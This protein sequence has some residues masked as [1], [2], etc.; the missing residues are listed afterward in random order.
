MAL[1][2]ARHRENTYVHAEVDDT[3]LVSGSIVFALLDVSTTEK[4]T[5]AISLLGL[6]LPEDGRCLLVVQ[7]PS[8]AVAGS[9][10]FKTYM[11]AILDG[12][13]TEDIVVNSQT[14]E[15][16]SGA[17]GQEAFVI[18]IGLGSAQG[19][20][21]FGALFAGDGGAMTVYYKLYSL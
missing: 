14:V 12:T 13:T 17:T 21:K 18:N 4:T 19:T 20:I 2:R 3:L 10:T 1:G 8:D 16:V 6:A 5:D 9:M 7:R 11:Q 15:N